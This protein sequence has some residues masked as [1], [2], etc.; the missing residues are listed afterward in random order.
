[1]RGL[2]NPRGNWQPDPR[3]LAYGLGIG[4]LMLTYAYSVAEVTE[5]RT[6][7]VRSRLLR[8]KVPLASETHP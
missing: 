3:H 4:L 6:G 5:A 2:L 7:S 1:L 8:R